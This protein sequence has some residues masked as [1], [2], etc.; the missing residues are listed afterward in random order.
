VRLAGSSLPATAGL[1]EVISAR[2]GA[3]RLDQPE[4]ERHCRTKGIS[5]GEGC[6]LRAAPPSG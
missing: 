3:S 5:T 1:S 2:E 4:K 6:L